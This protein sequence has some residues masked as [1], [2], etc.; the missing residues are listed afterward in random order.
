MRR[1]D[2][3]D[4]DR[5]CPESAVSDGDGDHRAPRSRLRRILVAAMGAEELSWTCIVA[6]Q[7]FILVTFRPV[8][9]LMPSG[10]GLVGFV[11]AGMGEAWL[12]YHVIRKLRALWRL[13][14]QAR[15]IPSER[16]DPRPRPGVPDEA[17]R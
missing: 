17:T 5:T 8:T 9:E 12:V 1:L 4:H 16:D 13:V 14:S 2:Q 15:G 3:Q 6:Y 7:V 10:W 11:V